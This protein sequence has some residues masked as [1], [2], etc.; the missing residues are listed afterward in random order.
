[1][2]RITCFT[3]AAFSVAGLAATPAA[4]IPASDLP[5]PKVQGDVT[6]LTGGVGSDE[7]AA[8]RKAEAQYPLSLEFVEHAR[9]RDEYLAAIDVTITGPHGGTELKAQ[10]DGPFLLA[11]LPAGRYT[12]RA[13]H[14]GVAK[15]RH[16]SV[17]GDKP[18]RLVFEW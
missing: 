17:A 18:Q 1:M 2:K 4:A 3:L 12:V 13:E 7:S 6:Y 9:P 15:T 11:Q 5:A 8:M 16:V 14:D 10:S